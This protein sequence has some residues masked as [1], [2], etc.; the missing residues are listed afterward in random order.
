MSA[1]LTWRRERGRG[2]GGDLVVPGA[3]PRQEE[4]EPER[5][6]GAEIPGR[7]E[8]PSGKARTRILT[9]VRL[10]CHFSLG[11]AGL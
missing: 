4:V 10:R 3:G 2:R 7:L 1:N 11:K 6:L 5:G 8:V 9:W